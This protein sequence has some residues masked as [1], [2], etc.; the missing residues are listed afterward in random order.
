MRA[1]RGAGQ[2]SPSGTRR[3]RRSSPG[4]RQ[5][6]SASTRSWTTSEPGAWATSLRDGS[7][8][9][10][11]ELRLEP[12]GL[13]TRTGA[14]GVA[15]F[16]LAEPGGS[17]LV[18]RRG[19]D[20]AL[21]PENLGWWARDGWM[22]AHARAPGFAW[23]VFDDRPSTGRARRSR[24]RA[25]FAQS[26][27][28]QGR[29]VGA[30]RSVPAGR[31]RRA[32]LA[33]QRDHEGRASARPVGGLRPSL[34]LPRTMNLGTANLQLATSRGGRRD[35]AF[36]V[37]EFRRPEFEVTAS[38][39]EGP[40]FV[41]DHADVTVTAALLRGRRAAGRR[42]GDLDHVATPASF[43]PAQ[44]R[45]TSPSG[46]GSPGGSGCPTSPRSP[47]RSR[48]SR[49]TPTPPATRVLRRLRRRDPAAATSVTARPPS[50]T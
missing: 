10:G 34:K 3:R 45:T 28:R 26:A 31:V 4:C 42:G 1:A 48:P 40:H 44:P 37:Q 12:A 21:L 36:Q 20:V 5:R 23:H 11:V 18:A 9:A 17:L 27:R 22:E 46:R 35:H 30:A 32:R 47:R 19:N 13:T 49:R 6:A 43:T 7:P 33:G 25:G 14:D 29:R 2:G 41:G 24:S 50:W 39:S 16:A 15:V 8:L 38:A